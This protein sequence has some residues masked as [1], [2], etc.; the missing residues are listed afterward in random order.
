MRGL[1]ALGLLPLLLL[2]CRDQADVDLSVRVDGAEHSLVCKSGGI[3]DGPSCHRFFAYADALLAPPK[4][5]QI[6]DG[7]IP[8]ARAA[9]TGTIRGWPIHVEDNPC[10]IRGDLW[11]TILN[12]RDGQLLRPPE[13]RLGV[14][15]QLAIW[16]FGSPQGIHADTNGECWRYAKDHVMRICFT[17]GLASWPAKP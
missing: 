16:I 6:C 2:G 15:K 5:P 10:Q 13:A 1:I 17:N 8:T 4:A 14:T 12:E 11:L 7:A 9:V 3:G